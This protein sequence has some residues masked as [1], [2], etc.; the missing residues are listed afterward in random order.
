MQLEEESMMHKESFGYLQKNPLESCNQQY[1]I[2]CVRLPVKND[3]EC[4]EV[5]KD[6]PPN[7]ETSIS[8]KVVE[9][10]VIKIANN[11]LK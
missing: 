7:Q 6:D 9:K 1:K 4:K 11:T 10:K 3:Q 5:R 2:H 8:Q